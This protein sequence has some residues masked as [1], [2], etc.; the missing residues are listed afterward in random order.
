MMEAHSQEIFFT[1]L[2]VGAFDTK[3]NKRYL[4]IVVST[5]PFTYAHGRPQ[6]GG[7]GG[8]CPPGRPK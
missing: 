6:G 4:I 3:Y 8:T 2:S 7:Q 5:Q 1:C